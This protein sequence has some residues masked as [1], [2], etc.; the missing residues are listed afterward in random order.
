MSSLSDT[1]E[2]VRRSD[3]ERGRRQAIRL[4]VAVYVLFMLAVVI[5]MAVRSHHLGYGWI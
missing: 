1:E 2:E 3:E 4:F 5:L